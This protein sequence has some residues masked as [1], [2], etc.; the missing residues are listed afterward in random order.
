MKKFIFVITL[1]FF[2]FSISY[3]GVRI[4]PKEQFEIVGSIVVENNTDQFNIDSFKKENKHEN[5]YTFFDRKISN[6][7]YGEELKYEKVRMYLVRHKDNKPYTMA[8]ALN[9]IEE[10]DGLRPSLA[11]VLLAMKQYGEI[12]EQNTSVFTEKEIERKNGY[13]LIPFVD[14]KNGVYL[15]YREYPNE[16]CDFIFIVPE[17][18]EKLSEL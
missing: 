4:E 2:I 5:V 12:F 6:A 15:Y 9:F 13:H 8:D 10:K 11:W 3:A 16:N 1:S 7:A 14:I 17:N 18:E